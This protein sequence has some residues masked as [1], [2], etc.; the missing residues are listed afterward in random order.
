MFIIFEG[1][2]RDPAKRFSFEKEF[3]RT[4]RLPGAAVYEGLPKCSSYNNVLKSWLDRV[5]YGLY[6]VLTETARLGE[7]VNS[8]KR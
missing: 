8:S 2:Q 7:T 3:L 4:F 5:R 1:L 6:L